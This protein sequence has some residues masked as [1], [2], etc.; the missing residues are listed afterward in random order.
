[1]EIDKRSSG[2]GSSTGNEHLHLGKAPE[3][4]AP[5]GDAIQHAM[6]KLTLTQQRQDSRKQQRL[7]F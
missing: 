5:N 1:M 6:S 7:A 3:M 2:P 4:K